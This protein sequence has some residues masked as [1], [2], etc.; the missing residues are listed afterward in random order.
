MALHVRYK[1]WYISL[2]FS[3]KLLRREIAKLYFS[4]LTTLSHI[5]FWLS[6]DCIRQTE[7][8]YIIA[9]FVV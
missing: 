3:V 2:S 5:P 7:W 1:S 9:R 4:N 6:Y 8:L